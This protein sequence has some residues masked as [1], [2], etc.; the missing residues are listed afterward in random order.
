VDNG[1]TDYLPDTPD[2][3]V[4]E[5]RIPEKDSPPVEL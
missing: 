4:E 1:C 3:F 2:G 5:P